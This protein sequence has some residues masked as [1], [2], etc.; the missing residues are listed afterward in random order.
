MHLELVV[1][2]LLPAPGAPPLPAL[3][4]LLARARRTP[5]KAG[6]LESWL[7]G[8]FD[9]DEDHFPAGALT[10]L[11]CGQAPGPQAGCAP[12]RSTCAPIATA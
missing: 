5:G 10:A 7:A 6:K 4:L 11:A 9:L 12:T 2:A 1:P 3:E 8:A